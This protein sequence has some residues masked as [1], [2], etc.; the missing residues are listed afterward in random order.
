MTIATDELIR[1]L[2]SDA[3][4]VRRLISPWSAAARILG[5]LLATGVVFAV[6]FGD[7]P[8]FMH[9]V[10][11]LRLQIEMVG[12]LFTGVTAILVAFMTSRPDRSRAWLLLPLPFLVM[13]LGTSGYG[14]MVDLAD[15]RYHGL[16]DSMNCLLFIVGSGLP[17]GTVLLWVLR[18]AKPLSPLPVAIMGALGVAALAAFFLQFIHPFDVTVLDLGVHIIAMGIVTTIIG[19]VGQRRIGVD[20]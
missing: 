5:V 19:M 17:I 3:K 15:P 10:V 2:A 16:Q 14:C 6:A 1:R 4:P 9:R 12:T 8:L 7:W 18:Q 11:Q 13:W 20:R